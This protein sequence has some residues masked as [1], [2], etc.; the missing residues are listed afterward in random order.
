MCVGLYRENVP[1]APCAVVC[2]N[3]RMPRSQRIRQSRAARNSARLPLCHPRLSAVSGSRCRTLEKR[4]V[5]VQPNDALPQKRTSEL[6]RGM[7][8]LCQKQTFPAAIKR[9]LFDHF[10]GE[11]EDVRVYSSRAMA[12]FMLSIKNRSQNWTTGADEAGVARIFRE[13]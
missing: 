6:S 4:R 1:C 11:C 2:I 10:V 3:G 9:S 7:S 8:A 5:I 13:L 12:L